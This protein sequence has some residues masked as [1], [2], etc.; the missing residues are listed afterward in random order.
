MPSEQSRHYEREVRASVRSALADGPRRFVDVVRH[1]R[2]A[3]P[4]VVADV[5]ADKEF[6]TETSEEVAL[7]SS[8]SDEPSRWLPEGIE[9]N[10]VLCSWY[11]TDSC[12]QRVAKLR[13]WNGLRIAFLGTPRLFEWFCAH[14]DG[15]QY[16]LYDADTVVLDYLRST[17]KYHESQ[18]QVHNV[19]GSGQQELGGHDFVFFDPPW[20]PEV[21]PAWLSRAAEMAP[22]G[23]IAFA[24]FPELTRAT[25]RVER[26]ELL[27]A[28]RASSESIIV[29]SEFL[30]YH[31]PTFERAELEAAGLSANAPWKLADLVLAHG[32]VAPAQVAASQPTH[33]PWAEVDIKGMRLF[34]D[35]R[36]IDG[37]GDA[38][39]RTLPGGGVRLRSPSRRDPA[40]RVANVLTSRGH[41]AATPR[42]ADLLSVLRSIADQCAAGAP[43]AVALSRTHIDDASRHVLE[44]ILRGLDE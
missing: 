42:P 29:I 15:S 40:R 10:P 33:E 41:G 2:G 21:Y 39:L 27:D 19:L 7:A 4:T 31:V 3:Y 9:G 16:V 1:C 18:L 12:C 43:S 36:V 37:S 34:V 22:G 23:T 30:E 26:L 6:R 17:G 28:V 5:L 32:L 14:H 25:A 38:L 20:Y 13:S 44:E 11:F 24:L 8:G 35:E